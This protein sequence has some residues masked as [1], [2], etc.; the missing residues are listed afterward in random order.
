MLLFYLNSQI[1]LTGYIFSYMRFSGTALMFY[2]LSFGKL[3]VNQ[4]T[5]CWQK[6]AKEA[7]KG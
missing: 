4:L 7:I 1:A 2:L 6:I 5:S 3:V